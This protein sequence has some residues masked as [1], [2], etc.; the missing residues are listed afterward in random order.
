M[1]SPAYWNH[2]TA[3][4]RWIRDRVPASGRILDAGCGDGTLAAFLDNGTLTIVG[5][6]PSEACIR[7]ARLLNPS[8]RLTFRCCSFEEYVSDAPFDAVIFSASLHHMDMTAALKKARNHLKPGGRILVVGLAKPSSLREHLL[9]A[10]R[11][12]P[13]KLLSLLHR[14]KPAEEMG[15]PVS[16]AFPDMK[17]VREALAEVLPGAKIRLALHYRYLLEW[18]NPPAGEQAGN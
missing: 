1:K 16:H 7:Q 4:Y 17:T 5:I 3:Y 9:E 2:N 13:S 12:I 6:D 15:I 8:P 14:I 18:R 10:A 11:V